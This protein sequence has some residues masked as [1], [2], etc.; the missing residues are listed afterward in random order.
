MATISGTNYALAQN[1]DYNDPL[2]GVYNGA[3]LCFIFDTVELSG[4]SAGDIVKMGG[5]VPAGSVITPLSKITFDA[6]GGSTTMQVGYSQLTA[7]SGGY[8]ETGDADAYLGATST[9]SAGSAN[10]PSIGKVAQV[11]G[12]TQVAITLTASGSYT[13]TLE[14]A[15]CYAKF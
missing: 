1:K 8:T 9:V 14:L 6:F 13:G 11:S 5:I 15:L 12:N 10:F 7:V 2:L 3:E 4:A